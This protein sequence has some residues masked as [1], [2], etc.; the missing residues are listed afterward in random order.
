MKLLN[1]KLTSKY[2]ML[3][4]NFEINFLAKTRVSKNNTND[5]LFD[6]GKGLFYPIETILIGKNSSGK[7]TT[8]ELIYLILLFLR[9]GRISVNS[10]V[11]QNKFG[12]EIMFYENNKI[13]KY[14]ANFNRNDLI[15]K[16]FMV[17][18]DEELFVSIDK[19]SYKK[20]LSNIKFHKYKDFVKN[21]G[22][23][24]SNI[25]KLK[26]NDIPILVDYISDD[27]TNLCSIINTINNF[28]KNSDIFSLIV[29]LFDDS[30]EYLKVFN[31]NGN[32][33]GFI[34][35]RINKP[36]MIVDLNTLKKILSGG[37]YRGIYL[38]TASIISF[39][40]GGHILIDEIEKSFNKNFIENLI[41]LFNDKTINKKMASLIHST[42]YAELLDESNRCD[43]INIL[44]R[45]GDVITL[46][47]LHSSYKVRTDISKSRQFNQ[48]AFDNF[49]NYDR[50]M[51]LRRAL[52][53]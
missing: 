12:F 16:N 24:T 29:Q 37:T 49:L 21:I 6:L 8:L 2:K 52:N 27:Q 43:N 39:N 22:G 1:L 25:T 51:K 5:E 32:S 42:H 36:E 31:I 46:K 4:E 28:Y 34:F 33:A 30:V 18:E 17:L 20:D 9:T 3:D 53:K 14:F 10:I 48:N 23:D 44:H 7:S 47:N 19:K 40:C 50:L 38:F 11:D 45:N 15:N 13:Y 35:K 41:I 26:I